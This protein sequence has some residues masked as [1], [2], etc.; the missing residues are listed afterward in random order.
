M[1]KLL[2]QTGDCIAIFEGHTD[3]IY[4]LKVFNNIL[5]TGSG[6]KSVRLWDVKVHIK[7]HEDFVTVD[8]KQWWMKLLVCCL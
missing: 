7:L 3:G 5:Y 6:D 4:C 8:H 1:Y 2:T